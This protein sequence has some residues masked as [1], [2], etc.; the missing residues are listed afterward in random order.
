MSL[1]V[2][3]ESSD[4]AGVLDL[5]RLWR[6]PT[7]TRPSRGSCGSAAVPNLSRTRSVAVSR[8]PRGRG[9]ATAGPTPNPASTTVSSKE[10]THADDYLV[11]AHR[12]VHS[13]QTLAK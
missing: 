10:T 1:L 5:H 4:D 13:G 3:A 11:T 7:S 12:G 8:T 6:E 9:A 2:L